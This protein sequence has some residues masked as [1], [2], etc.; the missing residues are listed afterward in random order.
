MPAS[1]VCSVAFIDPQLACV[2]QLAL[3]KGGTLHLQFYREAGGSADEPAGGRQ[4]LHIPQFAR[5]TQTRPTDIGSRDLEM[6]GQLM[7]QHHV[8]EELRC[9]GLASLTCT[10]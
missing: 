2:L 7:A 8:P 6:L 10:S 1:S 3:R 5:V 9:A 4:T